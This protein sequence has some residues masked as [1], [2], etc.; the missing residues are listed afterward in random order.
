MSEPRWLDRTLV[1]GPRMMLC[2]NEQQFVN[3]L[4][5]IGEPRGEFLQDVEGMVTY[6]YITSKGI[7]CLVCMDLEHWRTQ[8]ALQTATVLVHEAVHVW[9]RYRDYLGEH[10]PS[11]EFEAYAI[12]SISR[13]LMEAYVEVA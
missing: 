12:E 9:Q 10:T 5:K 1:W 7:V 11:K 13:N 3:I 4:K 2:T 8:P 6:T